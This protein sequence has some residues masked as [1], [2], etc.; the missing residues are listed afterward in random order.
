MFSVERCAGA[1]VMTSID[2]TPENV[3]PDWLSCPKCGEEIDLHEYTDL[4]PKSR[5]GTAVYLGVV[6]GLI[7]GFCLGSF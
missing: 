7:V 1:L 5:V 2:L 6:L 3:E 4:S